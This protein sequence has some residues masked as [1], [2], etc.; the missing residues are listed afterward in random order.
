MFG[1]NSNEDEVHHINES[2]YQTDSEVDITD[3][4]PDFVHP[5]NKG[6]RI[7]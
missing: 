1:N 5:S 2:S 6:E 3:E 7:K 4:Y